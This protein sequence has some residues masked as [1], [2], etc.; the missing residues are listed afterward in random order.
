MNGKS[1]TLRVN[2]L[3]R[4]E[5]EGRLVVRL[6]GNRATEVQLSIF[7]PPRFFEAFLRGRSYREAPDMT[8]RI[9]GICPVAYLMSACHAMED[10]VGIRVEG[11]LRALRR[12][13]YSGEWIE[14][15]ALHVFLLHA[16]DFLGYPDAMAMAKEHGEWV[17][18]GLRMKKAGNAVME[19]LG[20]REIHP[21]N[22]QVGGFYRVP[23][24]GEL[25]E[26]LPE[27]RWGR[28]AAA[29]CLEWASSFTYPVLERDYEL[30]ALRHP[31]E[32]PMCEGRVV[33]SRGLDIEVREYEQHFAEEQVPH[34]HALHTRRVGGGSCLSG[35]L[36]RYHLNFDRLHPWVQQL[37]R[38]MG[39]SPPVKNPFRSLQIR[40]LEIAQAFQQAIEII[41]AYVPPTEAFVPATPRAAIGHGA[42]EAPR[43]LLYHRYALDE[44][45]TIAEA[46]IVPPTSRNQLAI[47]ED[48]FAIAPELAALPHAKATHRAEQVV[49]NHDPCISCATHFLT[50]RIERD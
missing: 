49:R 14:S 2:Y 36:A 48:F 44:T 5:G 24:R 39:L 25:D 23:G 37:A 16:P 28:E 47:E 43:G 3:A 31:Q 50:L 18:K 12:L 1:R 35:P 17:K 46:R 13:I 41:E 10:A 9:C 4:V 32:Y 29:E 30:V 6:K 26:L 45:G 11:P 20:G 38:R 21:I 22:I 27:L 7:E 34:S 33:S 15:H 42:T 40:L 19:R 8:S